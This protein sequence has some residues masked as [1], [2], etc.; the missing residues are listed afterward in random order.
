MF[1]CRAVFGRERAAGGIGQCFLTCSCMLAMNHIDL[2]L[3]LNPA[4]MKTADFFSPRDRS[5][6]N[7]EM[8]IQTEA[9]PPPYL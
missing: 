2:D 6:E 7:G 9:P 4:L 8:D 1:K 3:M 5:L